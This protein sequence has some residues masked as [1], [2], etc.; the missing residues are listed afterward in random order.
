MR[1]KVYLTAFGDPSAL[2]EENMLE[3]EEGATLKDAL[4]KLKILPLLG[5]FPIIAV[6]HKR[7][8]L[9]TVLKDGDRITFVRYVV[10]G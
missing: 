8:K 7:A 4:K 9:S 3:L 2:D 6:N 5:R 1:V 10:G